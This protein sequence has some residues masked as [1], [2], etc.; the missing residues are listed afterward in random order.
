M[1]VAL[2]GKNIQTFL[3]IELCIYR[4]MNK[5]YLEGVQNGKKKFD[6]CR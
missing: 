3:M 6:K 4:F 2:Q 5:Q 1:R